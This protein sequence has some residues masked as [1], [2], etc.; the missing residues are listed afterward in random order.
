M[1]AKS[2]ELGIDHEVRIRVNEELMKRMDSKLNLLI[3]LVLGSV[4]I[5]IILHS[6]NLI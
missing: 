3:G 5:P 1:T 2:V 6:L 4:V